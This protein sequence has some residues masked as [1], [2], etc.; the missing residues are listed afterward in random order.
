MAPR[1]FARD[2]NA[3]NRPAGA[4]M[5]FVSAVRPRIVEQYPQLKSDISSFGKYVGQL[6]NNCTE[7]D[8]NHY[9]SITQS[10]MAVYNKQVEAYKATDGYAQYQKAKK[11]FKKANRGARELKNLKKTLVSQPKRPMSGYMLFANDVR[12][13]IAAANPDF[14]VSDLGKEIGRQWGALSE[15]AKAPYNAR[16]VQAKAQYATELAAYR[17]SAE[18]LNFC[19]AKKN[20]NKA[21]KD[22][23][24]EKKEKAK[25]KAKAAADKEK[26]KLA[27]AKAR[28][29]VAAAKLKAKAKREADRAKAVA[30]KQKDSAK[31][32]A[33][34]A[35]LAAKKAALKERLAAKKATQKAKEAAKKAA[36]KERTRQQKEKLAARKAALKAKVLAQRQRARDIAQRKRDAEKAKKLRMRLREKAQ[37]QRARIVAA[38]K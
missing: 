2:V 24:R 12:P 32:A 6:W 4:Y 22:A 5:R 1:K 33:A 7:E 20:I 26:A 21:A 10:E 15:E 25:A 8:K 23:E 17:Q 37:K 36:A 38:K 16:Y 35:K 28:A 11:E 34:K 31:K 19:E 14:K 27:K 3:P 18:W 30:K 13:Q 9:R 29:K